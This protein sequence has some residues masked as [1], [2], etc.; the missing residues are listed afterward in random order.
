MFSPNR[1]QIS[2]GIYI[3]W[4]RMEA[5][6]ALSCTNAGKVQVKKEAKRDNKARVEQKVNHV[7]Q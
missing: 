1:D 5:E 7:V 4:R 2:M 3:I 6:T